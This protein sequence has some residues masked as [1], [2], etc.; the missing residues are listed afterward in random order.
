[1]QLFPKL[2]KIDFNKLIEHKQGRELIINTI[3]D[4][5]NYTK[6]PTQINKTPL[7]ILNKLYDK[8][9][10]V[11]TKSILILYNL[12]LLE[13]LIK[14]K[15]INSLNITFVA[16]NEIKYI[17]AKNIYNVTTILYI[18]KPDKIKRKKQL[19]YEEGLQMELKKQN[20]KWDLII[21][22]PPYNK[23]LDIKILKEINT[24]GVEL[25]IVHP[26]TWILD[27]KFKSKLFKDYRIIINNKLK[28]VEFFNGNPIFNIGLFVPTMITHINN[29]HNGD[30][31]VDFFNDKYTTTDIFDITKYSSN[32]ST[33]V[34]PFLTNVKTDNDVWSHNKLEISKTKYHCQLAAIIGNHSKLN[35]MHKDDFYTMVM[36]DSE[37]NKGIRQPNLKRDGNPTPTFEFN[38]EQERNNF[39]SYL[40][41]D[42]ARFCLAPFK[43]GQNLSVGNAM[44]LIPWLD[45]TQ[46]WN[47]EKLYKHFNIDET[48]QAYITKFLPDYHNIRSTKED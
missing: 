22:N 13:F 16:D 27:R 10:D 29:N 25:I 45:F 23:N 36:K 14:D 26:S 12:E 44:G 24:L 47:D 19:S 40:K 20:K 46:E 1:M 8:I 4:S 11:E 43:D 38:T 7:D 33:I 17:V 32:W 18:D 34:Q 5:N 35:T 15:D 37:K 28:S 30:C 48:T 42:F 39:I 9:E 6:E 41:T 2:H 31:A 21:S 3:Y